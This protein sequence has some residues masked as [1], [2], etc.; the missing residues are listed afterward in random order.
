MWKSSE[1]SPGILFPLDRLEKCLEIS[2]AKT[3]RAFSLDD[4]KE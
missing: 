4:L 1:I 2:L 3:L